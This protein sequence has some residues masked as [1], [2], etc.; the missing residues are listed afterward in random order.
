[1]KVWCL[2]CFICTDSS[3][4]QSA[5]D[6]IIE[7]YYL[8]VYKLFEFAGEW[9]PAIR[10]KAELFSIKKITF[11]TAIADKKIISVFCVYGGIVLP[12]SVCCSN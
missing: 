1:M 10:N 4:K 5:F 6:G 3:D 9:I 12:T 8:L 2:K 7:S 11:F